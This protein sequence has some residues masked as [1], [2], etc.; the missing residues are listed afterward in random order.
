MSLS[1]IR[2]GLRS[3]GAAAFST[4]PSLLPSLR[5][6]RAKD[7]AALAEVRQRARFTEQLASGDC[8][9]G[10]GSVAAVPAEQ[11]RLALTAG[12]ATLHMHVESRI[13]ALVGEGFYTIGPCGEEL[14]AAFGLLLRPDDS[15]ALHYRHLAAQL[16]RQLASGRPL[17]DVLLD[18]ARGYTCSTLDPVSG[19]VHCA[20]GGTPRDFYVTST[21]ASQASV[22][23]SPHT[24]PRRRRRRRHSRAEPRRS[25][26][27][28]PTCRGSR[29]GGAAR[30]R[31][32]GQGGAVP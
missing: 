30:C 29:P 4:K 1:L 19:G 2:R 8:D 12:L 16:A 26:L 27:A 15:S 9:A 28:G 10:T 20:I 13:A 14:T 17:E 23:A 31:A 3:S 32:S 21:L 7:I 25:P 24:S 22:S 18:R 11:C 5:A 6:A